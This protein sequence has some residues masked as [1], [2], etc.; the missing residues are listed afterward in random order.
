MK[1]HR[2]EREPVGVGVDQVQANTHH[3]RTKVTLQ[4]TDPFLSRIFSNRDTKCGENLAERHGY[5]KL[6]T[7]RFLTKKAKQQAMQG[8]TGVQS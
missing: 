7:A 4:I 3:Q 5:L 6:R 8:G 2:R 1:A